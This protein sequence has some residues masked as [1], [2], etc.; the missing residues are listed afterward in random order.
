[1]G[2]STNNVCNVETGECDCKNMYIIGDKC[3]KCMEGHYKHPE[4]KDCMCNVLGSVG[5][6]CDDDGKCKCIEK[7]EGDK[8]KKCIKDHYDWPKCKACDCDMEGSNSTTCDIKTGQC[9]CK[10]EMI[11]GMK[12]DKCKE[13]YYGFPDCKD[14]CPGFWNFPDPKS[15]SCYANGTRINTD[16]NHK[17]GQCECMEGYTGMNCDICDK[18]YKQYF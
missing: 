9:P 11:E 3:E 14:C 15:C 6:S 18:G 8:C 16:C 12:C 7:V 2:G 4:C 10:D 13:G 17:T 1:M 5:K